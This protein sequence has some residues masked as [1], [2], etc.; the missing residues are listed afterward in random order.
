MFRRDGTAMLIDKGATVLVFAFY[1]HS[2]LSY[3]FD[4]TMVDESK[5]QFPGICQTE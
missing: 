2:D 4:Y 1:I 3:H 5:T